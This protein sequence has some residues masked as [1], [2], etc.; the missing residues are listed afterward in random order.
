MDSVF[1]DI[2]RR[3]RV[4]PYDAAWKLLEQGEYG[5]LAMQ[6]V[7]GYGYGIPLSYAMRGCSL[8]FHCAPSGFKLDSLDVCDRVS[9]CVVGR[10]EVMPARFTTAYESALAFGRIRRSL[11]E[12]ERLE[13]LRLLAA[14][15]SPDY[16]ETAEKYIAGSFGRTEVLRLDIEHVTGKG[17][18]IETK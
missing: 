6:G 8:Y 17:K 10:T 11:P 5:F 16:R 15:Y 13:A 9:F 2:R 18:R 14:K 12:A 7:N 1:R 3:D 4:L